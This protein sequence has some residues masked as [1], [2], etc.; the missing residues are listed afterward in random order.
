MRLIEVRLLRPAESPT[1]L[2]RNRTASAS[3]GGALAI[4]RVVNIEQV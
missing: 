3:A 2:A 1:A 4:M